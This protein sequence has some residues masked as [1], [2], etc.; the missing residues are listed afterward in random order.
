MA[1]V[2]AAQTAHS[3]FVRAKRWY[4][5]KTQYRIKIEDY[6][7]LFHPANEWLLSMVSPSK[8]NSVEVYTKM[9]QNTHGIGLNHPN[10]T[11]QTV[12]FNNHKLVFSLESS[13]QG[14]VGARYIE[15]VT[16]SQSAQ[17]LVLDKLAEISQRESKIERVPVLSTY[18]KHCWNHQLAPMRHLESVVLKRGMSEYIESDIKTFLESEKRYADRGIPWHRG[19]LFYGEPG[20]GKTSLAKALAYSLKLNIF[21]VSVADLKSD[22]DL[23]DRV[24]AIGK[25]EI[26][27]LEDIDTVNSVTDRKSEKGSVTM[28]GVLN[29]LDGVATPNG[30]I[31][32]MTTNHVESIDPAILRPGRVDIQLELER[33]DNDQLYRLFEIFYDQHPSIDIETHGYTTAQIAEIFKRNIDDPRAAEREIRC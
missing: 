28:S 25:R 2:S 15:I 22:S 23:I 10:E 18:G 30:M 5:E 11:E 4:G 13:G 21:Y 7:D 16:Q 24:S 20:M 31:T 17:Q 26:L 3:V 1:W 9:G 27:L 19:Y 8:R 29:V 12:Y 14:N 33:P 6:D 32:I